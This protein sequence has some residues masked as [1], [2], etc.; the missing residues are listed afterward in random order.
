MSHHARHAVRIAK[1]AHQFHARTQGS[2][3]RSF[4]TCQASSQSRHALTRSNNSTSS[5]PIFLH[6]NRRFNIPSIQ[7]YSSSSSSSTPSTPSSKDQS[8]GAIEKPPT[9]FDP[10]LTLETPIDP[11]DNIKSIEQVIAELNRDARTAESR[12]Y[13][14]PE[15]LGST[16]A[17]SEYGTGSDSSLPPPPPPPKGKPSRFWFYL[18]YILYYSA[19]G[20]LPVHLLMTKGETKDLKEKQEWKIAVLTD[21]RDKLRR[22]ESVEEEEALLSVGMD[23]SKREAEQK[24]DEAY[25]EDLLKSAEKL[26][27]VFGSTSQAEQIPAPAP[28]PTPAPAPP[29]VPRK[30]APPKTEKSYL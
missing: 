21:M 11:S 26:D 24:V 9:S 17:G 20:S 22:G 23:R 29:V 4:S 19:L 28:A 10:K 12:E 3:V 2:S 14:T 13:T 16:G 8:G 1:Q 6:Q 5:A 7:R 27:Y 15:E 25:F 30:P 18:Y